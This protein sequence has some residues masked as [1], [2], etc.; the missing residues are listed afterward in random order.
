MSAH[1]KPQPATAKP[2]VVLCR[3]ADGRERPSMRYNT[4]L[5]AR[6]IAERLCSVGCPA[7]VEREAT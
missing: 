2:F 5:E 4:E 3:R 1:Q 6:A 7:R